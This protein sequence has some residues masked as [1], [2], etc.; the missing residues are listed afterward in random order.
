MNRTHALLVAGLAA[1]I[2][3]PAFVPTLTSTGVPKR[4]DLA[5]LFASVNTNVV[6]RTTRAVRYYLASD[7]WSATNT[8]AELNALRASFAQWQAVSGTQLKFEDA[9]LVAPGIDVNTSDNTNVLFW[10]K[11]STLVNGGLSDISGLLAVTFISSFSPS[12]IHAQSD[13]V[14]N[15]KDYGWF[16]DYA[17]VGATTNYFIEGTALHEIGHFIGLSHSPAGGASMLYISDRGVSSQAGLSA[18]E[19]CAARVVYAQTNQ[20][21]LRGTLRGT[22]TRY[23]TN[24]LGAAVLAEDA[25][26]NITAGTVTRTNGFYEMSALPPGN[27]LVR[28]APLDPAA[29]TDYLVRGRSIDQP[30]SAAETSFLPTTNMPVTLTAG[31]TNTLNIAVVPG[32]PPFRISDLRG[33]TT[34]VGSFSWSSLPTI[35]R[36]GQSNIVIGVA[37]PNLPTNNATLTI[38]GDGLTLGTNIF[39]TNAFGTGLNFISARVSIASNATPGL[40]SFLVQKGTN[41]AYANGYLDIVPAQPDSNFDGLDDYFQ[42]QYFALWTATNTAPGA[43]PDG[44]GFTNAAEYTAG[45]VPTNAASLLRIDQTLHTLAGT[46]ITWRSVPGKRYQVS[47]RAQFGAG[48][49]LNL[50]STVTT[51]GPAAQYFDPSAPG[52][53]QFYRVEVLP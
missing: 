30:Y 52:G 2:S 24:L 41:T 15:G 20:L 43:D 18:D 33:A 53:R 14:F 40:R 36:P 9:G 1:A 7:A 17:I 35:L 11:S 45:T 37:S 39:T 50:G 6:N 23:G 27:Y 31:V 12:G 25:S 32:E 4:W 49:W 19:L 38:T 22:V 16:T 34:N 51:N 48:T 8:A 26:G 42:R 47:S 3:A 28:A 10:A 46:T 13:I 5:G 44:D 29:A 21:A